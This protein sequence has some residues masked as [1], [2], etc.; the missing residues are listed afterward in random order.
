MGF[1]PAVRAS[2]I[3]LVNNG[4]HL[5]AVMAFNAVKFPFVALP[6]SKKRFFSPMAGF[7]TAMLTNNVVTLLL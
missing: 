3:A 5:H 2:E 6:V 4:R 7:H 1:S